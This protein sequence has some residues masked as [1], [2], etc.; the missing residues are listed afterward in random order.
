MFLFSSFNVSHKFN[1]TSSFM[2]PDFYTSLH[3]CCWTFVHHYREKDV[4]NSSLLVKL[5]Q[6]NS[7]HPF[8]SLLPSPC[9]TSLTSHLHLCG[10]TFV[11]PISCFSSFLPSTC[12]T[13]LTSHLHLYGLTFVYHFINVAELLYIIIEKKM[14]PILLFWSSYSR[15]THFTLLTSQHLSNKL[16]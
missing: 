1:I 9:L 13:S 5:L 2:L 15:K 16:I 14:N 3:K 4:S 6:Q 8:S 11:H 10:L 7:F 12:L